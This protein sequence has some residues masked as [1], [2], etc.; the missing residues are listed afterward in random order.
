M[1][2]VG[3]IKDALEKITDAFAFVG[4]ECVESLSMKQC[5]VR[6]PWAV[7]QR[8]QGRFDHIFS[9]GNANTDYQAIMA[10]GI[11]AQCI[12]DFFEID[13]SSDDLMDAFGEIA[14]QYCGLLMDQEPFTENFGIL[15]QSVPQ[16]SINQT[17]F[18]RVWGVEGRLWIG[19]SWLY[20]GY[21][22]RSS[23]FPGR[24]A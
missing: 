12:P 17:F 10:V 16:Y 18:P 14:N 15:T 13:A 1:A 22:I 9:L 4:K 5:D 11:Q 3:E 7:V 24:S 6:E 23:A 20:I 21:A 8:L 19:E 2:I